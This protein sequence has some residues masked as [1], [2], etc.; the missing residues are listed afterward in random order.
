M[1]TV[2]FGRFSITGSTSC[3]TV[4]SFCTRP[5]RPMR[6]SPGRSHACC[7]AMMLIWV[8]DYHLI[9]LAAALRRF[10]FG[11]RIGFSPYTFPAAGPVCRHA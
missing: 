1:P 6:A 10:G 3:S 9:P 5:G 11:N 2:R 8:H 4:A 7:Q